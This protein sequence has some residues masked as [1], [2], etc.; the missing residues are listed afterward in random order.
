MKELAVVSSSNGDADEY[1]A[2]G[3][4]EL[5]DGIDG[6]ASRWRSYVEEGDMETPVGNGSYVS[7]GVG[8]A[9]E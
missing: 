6:V 7:N 5:A 4:D 9:A 1:V 2:D 3:R 8:G